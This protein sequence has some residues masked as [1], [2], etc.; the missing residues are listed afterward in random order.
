MR[1]EAFGRRIRHSLCLSDVRERSIDLLL[2]PFRASRRCGSHGAAQLQHQNMVARGPVHFLPPWRIRMIA[3]RFVSYQRR[4]SEAS[5]PAYGMTAVLRFQKIAYS[6]ATE[7]P[8]F[9]PARIGWQDQSD[10]MLMPAVGN[11]CSASSCVSADS[12][13]R[14]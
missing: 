11:G 4:P 12:E 3:G 1:L 2:R 9:N 8:G 5:Y 10:W 7:M 13:L 14:L 6:F